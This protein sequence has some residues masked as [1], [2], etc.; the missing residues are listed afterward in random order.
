M[1]FKDLKITYYVNNRS[2]SIFRLFL[3]TYVY[4][5]IFFS[6]KYFFDLQGFYQLVKYSGHPIVVECLDKG[7]NIIGLNYY[8][9]KYNKVYN[10]IAIVNSGIENLKFCINEKKNGKINFIAAGPNLVVLP[11]EH[12]SILSNTLIDIILTPSKWV[13]NNYVKLEP[14]LNNRV[15]EWYCGIDHIYWKD[16]G[17]K[18]N[19]ITFYLKYSAGPIPNN[20][21][22]YINYVEK[23]GYKIKIIEYNKYNR[24]KY[25]DILNKSILL[26]YFSNHES[27]GLAS[28]EAWSCNTPTL[29]WN[30]KKTFIGNYEINSSC[31]PYM[32]DECGNFFSDFES[33]KEIFSNSIKDYYKYAPRKWVLENMT[34]EISIRNLINLVNSKMKI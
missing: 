21:K 25:K 3:F 29:I 13:S 10:E 7:S 27:Q 14:K 1:K 34:Y 4:I 22:D 11:N 23:L 2:K 12:N 15:Y 16:E 19:I 31:C 9:Y 5:K 32:N 30:N 8:F 18:R 24:K 26:I 6:R 17:S 33:F 28:G 20:V